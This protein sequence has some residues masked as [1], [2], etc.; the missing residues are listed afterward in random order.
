MCNTYVIN[1]LPCRYKTGGHSEADETDS[2]VFLDVDTVKNR[3]WIDLEYFHQMTTHLKG[4]L[5]LLNQYL[6]CQ[7]K[8]D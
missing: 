7:L 2:L 6:H 5:D 3:G 8:E 4:G 1:V